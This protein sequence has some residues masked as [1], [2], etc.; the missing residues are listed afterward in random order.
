MLLAL[1]VPLLDQS[2]FVSATSPQERTC[3]IY[4]SINQS[5]NQSNQSIESINQSINQINQ[6]IHQ[7]NE[8]NSR[9]RD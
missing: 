7:I 6:S 9:T 5:I 4:Q 2:T 1:L 3:H 8:R